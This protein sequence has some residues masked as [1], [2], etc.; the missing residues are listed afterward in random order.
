MLIFYLR[1]QQHGK[2]LGS[3]N[4]LKGLISTYFPVWTVSQE[5]FSW[6]I[7]TEDMVLTVPENI[8]DTPWFFSLLCY[9]ATTKYYLQLWCHTAV[10]NC[11]LEEKY[12]WNAT[13]LVTNSLFDFDMNFE[14]SNTE[15]CFDLHHSTAALTLCLACYWWKM[16]RSQP[17]NDYVSP[18]SPRH[19]SATRF[20]CGDAAFRA[21]HSFSFT[22]K[23]HPCL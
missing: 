20:P 19:D 16:N 7:Q 15:I 12:I 5:V 3:T 13:G 4:S 18:F 2:L 23:M 17:L 1:I 8:T 9:I 22:P 6:G 11:E 14:F 10:D 21:M